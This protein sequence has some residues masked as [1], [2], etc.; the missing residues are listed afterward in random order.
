M[1]AGNVFDKISHEYYYLTSAEKKVAGY[2]LDHQ[3]ETPF[4]SI[5]ELAE[6]SGVAEATVSRFCRRLDYPGYNAFKLAAA[7]SAANHAAANP[8]AGEVLAEDSVG[9]MCQKIYAA[10][11]DALRETMEFIQPEQI[12]RA[13]DLLAAAGKVLCM[14]QGGSMI[15][16]EEAAHFF[17]TA[18]PKFFAVWD[19]HIQVMN[20]SQMEPG[21]VVLYF[22]YSGATRELLECTRLVRAQ[23]AKTILITRFPRS[24]GASGADLV[25]QC[26]SREGPIQL[27][28]IAARIAQLYLI[29]VLF[30]ELSRR[31]IDGCRERRGQVA[32]A[33][34]EK[35]L[36]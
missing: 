28:S 36:G 5:T 25:L 33:L 2:V 21:D 3:R 24:P 31:D 19:S 26:G 23:G 34:A 7:D 18:M 1:T 20:A 4:M 22:S 9:A 32:S 17:S 13:A 29:D 11:T 15:L 16:A 10:H 12:A 14:G 6:E 27:G 8:L 35:H 30:S